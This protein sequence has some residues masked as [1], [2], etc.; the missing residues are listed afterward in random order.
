MTGAICIVPIS[1]RRS[2]GP[3]AVWLLAAGWAEAAEQLLGR[4]FVVGPEGGVLSPGEA[5]AAASQPELHTARTSRK[6]RFRLL[7]TLIKDMGQR[8]SARQFRNQVLQ[9]LASRE[10]PE[11]VWQ[12]H[13]VFHDVGWSLAQKLQCP[14]VL[15]VDAPIVW[16]AE[17]WGVSRPVWGRW[18]ERYGEIPQIQ[19]ADLVTCPSAEVAE[20][21][22]AR[23]I[24]EQRI[25][26]TPGGVNLKTFHPS[27][28]ATEVRQKYNLQDKFVIGWTG[29]FR[30][31][32]GVDVA[33]R[34][35][36][37]FQKSHPETALLLV[38]DGP[39]RPQLQRLADELQLNHVV[40]T[41][42]LNHVDMPNHI[43]AMDVALVL[44]PP[45]G[46]FHYSP[47][48]LREYMACCVPV[49]APKSG[50]LERIFHDGEDVMLVEGRSAADLS[51]AI[52]A[53][54][55]NPER[56]QS[57]STA[58][59][60]LMEREGAWELQVTRVLERLGCAREKPG[61]P[62]QHLAACETTS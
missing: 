16:E 2:S 44:A 9:D 14:F 11:F 50:E 13:Q 47:L 27:A 19:R 40:F 38:G 8:G 21:L 36:A 45:N 58:A 28:G 32:H 31:F 30:R 4:S 48:K 3:L 62:H 61:R 23:G 22:T 49:I 35:F 25:M 1:H 46:T 20:Q 56:A 57:I 17:Q 51:R 7:R 6:R 41:G 43:A 53:L 10:Q 5:R 42:T 15:H 34:A 54:Y 37:T 26:V 12:H 33:L 18:L 24:D 39:E 55:S 59:R 52:Q 29:S 60:K